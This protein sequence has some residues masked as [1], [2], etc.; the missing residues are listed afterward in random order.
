MQ[1]WVNRT[2]L[3]SMAKHLPMDLVKN[4]VMKIGGFEVEPTLKKRQ[5]RLNMEL[6]ATQS[7]IETLNTFNNSDLR[8]LDDGQKITLSDDIK[9]AINTL[10]TSTVY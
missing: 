10:S 5:D 2:Q 6:S 7:S 1:A 9:G 3:V 8:H 4:L